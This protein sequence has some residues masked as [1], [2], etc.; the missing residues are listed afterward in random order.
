ML[1]ALSF[2]D[3][4]EVIWPSSVP[5]L[6]DAPK[7]LPGTSLNSDSMSLALQPDAFFEADASKESAS[8]APAV[9]PPVIPSMG[10]SARPG[11]KILGG[12]ALGGA[13][14][15]SHG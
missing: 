5:R 4:L 2:R 14:K 15:S 3:A 11:K 1:W 9:A 7:T 13:A 12:G 6:T 10:S 8:V